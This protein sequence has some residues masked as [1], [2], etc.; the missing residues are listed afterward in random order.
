MEIQ[1]HLY[2]QLIKWYVYL[3]IFIAYAVLMHAHFVFG[4]QIG[5]HDTGHSSICLFLE[6]TLDIYSNHCI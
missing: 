5:V 6:T 1:E 2:L 3:Q 4:K